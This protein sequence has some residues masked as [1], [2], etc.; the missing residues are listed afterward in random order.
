MM[1]VDGTLGA[2]LNS[3]LSVRF[4]RPQTGPLRKDFQAGFC[5]NY[6]KMDYPVATLNMCW[7]KVGLLAT[8]HRVQRSFSGAWQDCPS[9][10][11]EIAGGMCKKNGFNLATKARRKV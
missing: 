11:R 2:L 10:W 5:Y 7:K 6:C 3:D 9:G 1:C 8:C 4:E